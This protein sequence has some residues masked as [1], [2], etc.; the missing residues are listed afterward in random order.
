MMKKYMLNIAAFLKGSRVGGPG[1]R[2]ILWVQGCS[3]CCPGC[4]NQAYLSHEPRVLMRVEQVID[5]FRDFCEW[6]RA[7]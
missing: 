3:I 1:L 6:G 7:D 5:H 2:D 4:A